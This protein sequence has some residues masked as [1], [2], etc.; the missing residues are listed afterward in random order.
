MPALSQREVGLELGVPVPGQGHQLTWQ[1]GTE[2]LGAG[3]RSFPGSPARAPSSRPQPST[4]SHLG[5]TWKPIRPLAAAVR[6]NMINNA[7]NL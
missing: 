3:L 5:P 4:W 6:I 2:K 7:P 1:R